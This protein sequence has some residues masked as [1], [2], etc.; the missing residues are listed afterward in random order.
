MGRFGHT[1]RVLGGPIVAVLVARVAAPAVV[2]DDL[3]FYG[4]VCLLGIRLARLDNTDPVIAEE[5]VGAGKF[6]L[7]HVTGD[8]VFLCDRAYHGSAPGNRCV[9]N[10][11]RSYNL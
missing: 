5:V 9:R 1:R 6:D 8:A 7:G 3:A 2:N 11:N 10:E 4:M